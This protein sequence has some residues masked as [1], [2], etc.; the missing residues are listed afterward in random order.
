MLKKPKFWILLVVC[1]IALP[2]LALRPFAKS[3]C[4]YPGSNSLTDRIVSGR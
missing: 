2:F 3:Q 1:L 4:V